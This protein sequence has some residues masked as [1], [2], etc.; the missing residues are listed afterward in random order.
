MKGFN[1]AMSSIHCLLQC[2][3]FTSYIKLKDECTLRM[4]VGGVWMCVCVG[5]GTYVCMV[6]AYVLTVL[7]YVMLLAHFFS[8]G[9]SF[10]H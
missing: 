4:C 1:Y 7:K 10:A 6:Y 5:G 2:A 9:Q 8:S 3:L